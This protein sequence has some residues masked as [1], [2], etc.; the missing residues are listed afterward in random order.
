MPIV[1][2]KLKMMYSC[3]CRHQQER[4]RKNCHTKE[5]KRERKEIPQKKGLKGKDR[6]IFLPNQKE[7]RR[8]AFPSMEGN[9][10]FLFMC[11]SPQLSFMFL[12]FE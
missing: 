3:Y 4:E 11:A 12:E 8:N 5:R 6:I 10:F 9:S 7:V 1:N 2:E